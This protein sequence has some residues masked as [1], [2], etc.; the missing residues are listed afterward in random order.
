MLN[1]IRRFDERGYLVIATM[2]ETL[3]YFG[4]CGYGEHRIDASSK[5]V[6]ETD[7]LLCI[8]LASVDLAFYCWKRPCVSDVKDC[9]NDMLERQFLIFYT[10]IKIRNKLIIS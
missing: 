4:P 5:A 6:Y 7:R 9:V 1:M 3:S 10:C 8:I 2:T